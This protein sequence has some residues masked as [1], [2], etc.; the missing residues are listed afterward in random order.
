MKNLLSLFTLLFLFVSTTYGQY[1][2]VDFENLH[3]KK[4][5]QK[6]SFKPL[7]KNTYKGAANEQDSL[8]LVALYNAT[9]GENWTRIQNW[10][11]GNVSTWDG[12]YLDETGRVILI[13]L[14]SNNLTGSIPAEI[15]NLT[16]LTGFDLYDNNFD[17]GDLEA[18]NISF[19]KF[20]YSPQKK[21]Q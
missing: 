21:Y 3:G 2:K 6:K 20:N 9:D 18:A 7:Q 12:V 10:L 16:N 4:I 17:F 14:K 1:E 19:D 5:S 11:T 8:A 13:Y 15:G